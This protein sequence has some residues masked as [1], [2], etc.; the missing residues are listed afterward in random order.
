MTIQ[1]AVQ[2]AE[3]GGWSPKK[4][5]SF[6]GIM[7]FTV[8]EALLD[9]YFWR[10][11]GKAMGWS[12]YGSHDVRANNLRCHACGEKYTDS[13]PC[14]KNNYSRWKREWYRLI[15]NLIEGKSIEEYFTNL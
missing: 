11:L 15:D 5:H 13:E 2:K 14:K 9:P 6:D 12:E 10:S 7:Q 1:Q 3:I 8:A 4:L